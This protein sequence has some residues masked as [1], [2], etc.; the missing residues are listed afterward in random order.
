[1]S[2]AYLE[3]GLHPR[4]AF[5]FL[6]L[7]DVRLLC[8]IGAEEEIVRVLQQLVRHDNYVVVYKV[9]VRKLSQLHNCRHSG[10][11]QIGNF[12]ELI[13]PLLRQVIRAQHYS[14]PLVLCNVLLTKCYLKWHEK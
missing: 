4:S 8:C 9:L 11:F 14:S 13:A 10:N 7:F 5:Q 6:A 3:A 12:G 2:Y 1:V